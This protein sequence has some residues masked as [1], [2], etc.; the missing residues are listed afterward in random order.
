MKAQWDDRVPKW[1]SIDIAEERKFD[2]SNKEEEKI[3]VV[4]YVLRRNG[5]QR[6]I[7]EAKVEVKR[8]WYGIEERLKI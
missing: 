5:L 7:I 6:R 1:R 2:T 3:L 8:E 4:M